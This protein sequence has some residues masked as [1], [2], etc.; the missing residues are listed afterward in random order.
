MRAIGAHH[1]GVT[2]LEQKMGDVNAGD[3]ADALH[4]RPVS[5][6]APAHA[7]AT[8]QGTLSGKKSDHVVAKRRRPS[9][10]HVS[11]VTV[12]G[13]GLEPTHPLE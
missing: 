13:V 2:G 12:P 3:L 9:V 6:V 10:S 4:Q 11:K 8:A 7:R 5:R 1:V